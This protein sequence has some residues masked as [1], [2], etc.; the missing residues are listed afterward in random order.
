MAFGHSERLYCWQVPACV[1]PRA[2][3]V[4]REENKILLEV[5]RI[6][7]YSSEG[8]FNRLK[9]HFLNVMLVILQAKAPNQNY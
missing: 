7:G 5:E 2:F 1:I 4:Y 6:K 3:A 8:N 9:V